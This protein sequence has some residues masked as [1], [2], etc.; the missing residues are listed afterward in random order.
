MQFGPAPPTKGW[1][2]FAKCEEDD[3]STCDLLFLDPA[4]FSDKRTMKDFFA[5]L[6]WLYEA[7]QSGT[8]WK[9]I[10]RDGK[11]FHPVHSVT[12]LRRGAGGKPVP[13]VVQVMQWKKKRTAVRLLFVQSG[14]GALNIFVS[15]A[16]EKDSDATPA[17]EKARAEE[18]ISAFFAALDAKQ[19]QLIT[20]QGGRDATPKFA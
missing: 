4:T 16:F 8:S 10:F 17:S 18:N 13:T 5:F 12:V 2:I 14:L 6:Q 11:L 15:H 20:T 3:G 1:R 7:A 19:L 9:D